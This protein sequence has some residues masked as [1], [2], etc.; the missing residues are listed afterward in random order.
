MKKILFLTVAAAAFLLCACGRDEYRI[1]GRVTSNELEGVKIFLVPYGHEERENVDSVL[2]HNHEFEFRG[3]EH[4]MCTLRLI[5]H[6][7]HKGQ[8]LLVATEPGDIYVTIGPDSRGGGTPQND[9]LQVWK[10]L[11]IEHNRR[12]GQLYDAG[13]KEEATEEHAA[14]RT[15]TQQMALALGEDSILGAFLLQLYPLTKE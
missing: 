8:N 13:M 14:Y 1:H 9:S 11:T 12:L 2:I 15:R 7:R 4:W 3:R 10:D 6:E 5:S